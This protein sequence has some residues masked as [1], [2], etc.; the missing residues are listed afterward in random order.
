M[1]S[2]QKKKYLNAIATAMALVVG[3]RNQDYNSGGIGLRDY[4]KINGIW[5]PVQMVDMKLKR[6]MSQVATWT[7]VNRHAL[8]MTSVEV[9]KLTESMVDLINYAAFVVC[10]AVSLYDDNIAKK[11]DDDKIVFAHADLAE[12]LGRVMDGWQKAK[13]GDKDA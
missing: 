6:A 10:E 7:T 9:E 11:R 1:E 5:A 3:Q 8:P 13:P 12:A 4:W 2:D